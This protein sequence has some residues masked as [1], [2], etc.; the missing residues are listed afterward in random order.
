MTTAV[1]PSAVAA[2]MRVGRQLPLTRARR[3]RHQRRQAAVPS[4][5]PRNL[6]NWTCKC[7]KNPQS[8]FQTWLQNMLDSL[9]SHNLYEISGLTYPSTQTY[10][11]TQASTPRPR[12]SARRSRSCPASRPF[13]L[14]FDG[15]ERSERCHANG[16]GEHKRV[17][18]A[19]NTSISIYFS[20]LQIGRPA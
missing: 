5:P 15:A 2:E 8:F 14:E 3:R 13:G 12:P 16:G 4:H 6:H 20:S 11:P 10:P 18:L 7:K 9:I 19:Y 1:T 17:K